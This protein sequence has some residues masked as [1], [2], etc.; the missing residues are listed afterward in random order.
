[1]KNNQKKEDEYIN[2]K[3]S[4]DICVTVRIQDIINERIHPKLWQWSYIGLSKILKHTKAFANELC[5][6]KH[7]TMLDVGC[8][9][10][11]YESIFKCIDKYVGLD[12]AKH[13]CVD[14]VGKN[15]DMPFE[16][17]KFDAL[18]STQVLEHTEKIDKTISE[19]RRVVRPGGLLFITIPFIFPE[20]EIPEDFY[21][22]TRYGLRKKFK[23]FDIVEITPL[24]GYIS[25]LVQMFNNLLHYLPGSKYYLFPVFMFNNVV[26]LASDKCVHCLLS[27]LSKFNSD[28]MEIYNKYYMGLS[29]N[30]VIVLK[31]KK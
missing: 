9:V 31:N 18:I 3:I 5:K 27:T 23:D 13:A 2:I 16:D 22:F 20:H 12:V 26:A 21:R 24:N 8:G 19:M 15:W 29:E 6:G 14:V 25:T 7:K 17:N 4:G 1:M 10:K 11:P 28:Y 30:Y